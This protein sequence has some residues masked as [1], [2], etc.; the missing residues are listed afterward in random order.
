MQK[1]KHIILGFGRLGE[2]VYVFAVV[3]MVFCFENMIYVIIDAYFL[4]LRRFPLPSLA[5]SRAPPCHLLAAR[6]N[7]AFITQ[8][9]RAVNV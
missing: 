5:W 3:V 9:D 1:P 6:K 8:V 4:L 2:R 7:Q